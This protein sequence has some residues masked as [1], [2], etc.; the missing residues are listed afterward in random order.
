[1]GV[2]FFPI[3]FINSL[4]N[5]PGSPECLIRPLESYSCGMHLS[6]ALASHAPPIS[7]FV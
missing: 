3:R 7:V 5:S 2:V 6:F 4:W 1:M